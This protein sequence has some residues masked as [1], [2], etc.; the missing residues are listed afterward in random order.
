MAVEDIGK[1][2]VNAATSVIDSLL[3]P[4]GARLSKS[5]LPKGAELSE[6][7]GF[8]GGRASFRDENKDW[9]VR[10]SAFPGQ[11]IYENAGQNDILYPLKATGTGRPHGVVFPFTPNITISHSA[12]YD[13][14]DPIQNNYRYYAYHNS[15]I[16]NITIP[17][18][19]T[20]Q[21]QD[22]ARYLLAAFHFFRTATKSYY[23]SGNGDLQG[24][25]PPILNLNAY[26]FYV[27]NNVPVIITNFTTDFRQEVDYISVNLGA[28]TQSSSNLS[29]IVQ[30]LQDYE[31]EAYGIK[32]EVGS[33][34]VW[35][36]SLMTMTIQIM[37]VY[38]R[39][40]TKQFSLKKFASGEIINK[41]FI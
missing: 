29:N 3:D 12:N 38:S 36:P 26:G 11:D 21:N 9:R 14:Y 25:P 34:T 35:V 24:S 31:S 19:F 28:P 8:K 1:G 30:N 17:A 20:A 18:D 40:E 39:E 16:D 2:I 23:G 32:S 7:Q 10:I 37:P 33:N 27:F 13:S 41:G 5:G 15:A 22:E 4:S 6:T